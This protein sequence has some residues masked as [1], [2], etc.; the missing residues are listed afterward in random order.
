MAGKVLQ[1]KLICYLQK[2]GHNIK[3]L[4]IVG[5]NE[6]SEK[7]I[8]AAKQ[9]EEW[10]LIPV[11]AVALNNDEEIREFNGIPVKGSYNSFRE[12][13]HNNYVDQVVFSFPF[14]NFK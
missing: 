8:K 12:I 14:S 6:Q 5:L 2:K 7:F 10:G 3:T 1:R 13:I 11:G 4:L 9:H